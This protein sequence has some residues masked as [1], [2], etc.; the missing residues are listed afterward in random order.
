[1][2]EKGRQI[3]IQVET[4]AKLR[5]QLEKRTKAKS[6][7]GMAQETE[8]LPSKCEALISN[9]RIIPPQKKSVQLV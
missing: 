1:V 7:A 3:T 4:Q 6:A 9:T 8:H 5:P 2:G